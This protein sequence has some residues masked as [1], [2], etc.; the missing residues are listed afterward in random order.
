MKFMNLKGVDIPVL[1]Y[2]SNEHFVSGKKLSSKLELS[3]VAV[4]K[5]IQKLKRLGYHISADARKGYRIISRPDILLPTEI[6]RNLTTKYI[7]RQIFYHHQ[8]SSTNSMA[9]ESIKD[10][11]VHFREGTVI[12][13]DVQTTG[14]GRL[15]RTWYSPPGGLCITI[16]L[17]PNLEPVYI[18]RITLMTAVVLVQSIRKL[19]GIPVQIKW[20]NDLVLRNKKLCG[21]L[22]EMAA[23]SDRINYVVVGIGVNA[24]LKGEDFPKDIRGKSISLQEILGESISR[25]K[26][27]QLLLENFEKYYNVLQ[28]KEFAPIL[29]EWKESANYLGKKITVVSAEQTISGKAIDITPEGA[30]IIRKE[31]GELVHVLSGTVQ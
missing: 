8:V 5:Q 26:L 18:S 30:L 6:Q 20:P 14:R 7:G 21:I 4:W 9:K 16:I 29:E 17:F 19:Y 22:T 28:K 12:V 2:L 10:K 1:S 31:D 27:T 24:N 13:A 25:I 3:R 11:K 23:E 15:G